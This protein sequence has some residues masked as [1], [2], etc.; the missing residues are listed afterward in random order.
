MLVSFL[1]S[2]TSPNTLWFATSATA[3]ADSRRHI[4][5]HSRSATLS[6]LLPLLPL[7]LQLDVLPL[8][9]PLLLLLL[10]LPLLS[11]LSLPLRSPVTALT[12]SS[13]G[14]HICTSACITSRT[15]PIFGTRI[16]NRR[17]VLRPSS[18]T[19]VTLIARVESSGSGSCCNCN[20]SEWK[21]CYKASV[22]L[23]VAAYR[24][25]QIV[26]QHMMRALTCYKLHVD[27]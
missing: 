24:T 23:S 21:A 17:G 7:L 3:T 14:L 9:L 8:L 10:L 5:L 1:S 19:S 16:A 12:V 25:Q 11:I 26:Q 13:L 27:V 4:P 20:N 18:G 2:G 15:L 6:Q 22:M